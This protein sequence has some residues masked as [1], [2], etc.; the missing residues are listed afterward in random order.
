MLRKPGEM[1]MLAAER[2]EKIVQLVNERGSVRVSELSE[3]SASPKKRFAEIST[4]WNGKAGSSG[5]MVAPFH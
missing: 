3:G 1:A 2:G 4:G 5:V